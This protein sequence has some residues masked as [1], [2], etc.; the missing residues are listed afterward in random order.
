MVTWGSALIRH[1]RTDDAFRR[2]LRQWEMG[3][4]KPV[5]ALVGYLQAAWMSDPCGRSEH[6]A[7]SN[8]FIYTAFLHQSS[9]YLLMWAMVMPTSPPLFTVFCYAEAAGISASACVFAAD[10]TH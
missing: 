7:Q 9:S 8:S 6:L 2:V 3:V 4:V 5:G 1:C 10:F